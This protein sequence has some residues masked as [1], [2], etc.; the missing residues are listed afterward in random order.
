[1]TRS[2]IDWDSGEWTTEPD[3]DIH[4]DPPIEAEV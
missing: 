2:I 4:V 3:S 1:M